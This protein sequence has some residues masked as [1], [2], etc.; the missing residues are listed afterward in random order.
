MGRQSQRIE[1]YSE[2]QK[3]CNR[4]ESLELQK[5]YHVDSSEMRHTLCMSPYCEIVET[6]IYLLLNSLVS[7]AESC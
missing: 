5:V 4:L 3:I 1:D 2:P 7:F 6:A